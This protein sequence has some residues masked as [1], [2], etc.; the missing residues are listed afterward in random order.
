MLIS[1]Y[2]SLDNRPDTQI[3]GQLRRQTGQPKK[4][5]ANP[6]ECTAQSTIGRVAVA[7]YTLI[8]RNRFQY[9]HYFDSKHT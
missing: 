8:S 1:H 9:E 5:V 7:A 4:H 2:Q 6:V 3:S